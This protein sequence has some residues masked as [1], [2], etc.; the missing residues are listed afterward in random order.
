MINCFD[1]ISRLEETGV[2]KEM[3]EEARRK[4]TQL[5][6]EWIDIQT[7]RELY[8]GSE[9]NL[10]RKIVIKSAKCKDRYGVILG[11]DRL[12]LLYRDEFVNYSE[13]L[14]DEKRPRE[15]AQK[16]HKDLTSLMDEWRMMILLREKFER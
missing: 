8:S 10:L 1:D 14:D 11:L 6:G 13:L 9:I 7:A 4:Y 12:S 3:T 5:N 16:L 2:Q 15:E